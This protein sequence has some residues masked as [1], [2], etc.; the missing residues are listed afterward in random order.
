MK[1]RPIEVELFLADG[2]TDRHDEANSLFHH[3][4]EAPNN[5][6]YIYNYFTEVTL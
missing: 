5:L 1:I 3:L 2:R 6:G 4:A